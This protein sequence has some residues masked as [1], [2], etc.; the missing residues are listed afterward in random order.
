MFNIIPPSQVRGPL[1]EEEIKNR[2]LDFFHYYEDP[3]SGTFE[4]DRLVVDIPTLT[5]EINLMIKFALYHSSLAPELWS[6][7]SKSLTIDEIN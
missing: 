5:R 4:K 7:Y 3:I 1:S 6:K 2:L